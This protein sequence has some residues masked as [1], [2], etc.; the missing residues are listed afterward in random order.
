HALGE[1]VPPRV[2]LGREVRSIEQLL[3][4]E[5]ADALAAGLLDQLDVLVDHRLADLGQARFR[6][7]LDVAGLDQAAADSSGH[8]EARW[9]VSPRAPTRTRRL[10]PIRP[11]RSRPAPRAA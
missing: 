3:E 11:R 2:L 7:R 4:R 9:D 6:R 5:D 1:L 8:G 10:R